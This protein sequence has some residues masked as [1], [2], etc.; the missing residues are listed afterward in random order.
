M[1]FFEHQERA[2]RN[3]VLLVLYFFLAV[4]LIVVAIYIVVLIFIVGLNRKTEGIEVVP[5]AGYW[6]PEIFAY[7]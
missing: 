7:S 6:D 3:T 1:D 2:R 5:V 4:A